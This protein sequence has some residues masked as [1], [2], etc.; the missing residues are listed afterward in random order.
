[1]G[2]N[3]SPENKVKSIK[4]K[5]MEESDAESSQRLFLTSRD[6]ELSKKVSKKKYI[7]LWFV[8]IIM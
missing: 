1:M 5:T 2:F 4:K 3:T 7:W 8:K 6:E